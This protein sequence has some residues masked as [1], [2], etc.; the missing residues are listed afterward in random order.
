MEPT[1][2]DTRNTREDWGPPS[3]SQ[4]IAKSR[5]VSGC[6][7]LCEQCSKVPFRYA[8]LCALPDD[9]P[10]FWSLGTFGDLR[11]RNCPFC[12]LVESVCWIGSGSWEQ[13]TK[14]P[15]DSA[16]I[17]IQWLRDKNSFRVNEALLGS[18][19]CF[20]EADDA[21]L[22]RTKG[23][24][25]GWI[26]TAICKRWLSECE[27]RH[28][29]ECSPTPFNKDQ[30]RQGDS[31][32]LI[33][34][35]V[36]VEAMCIMDAPKSCRYLALSYVWGNSKD[37]RLV[38]NTDNKHVLAKPHALR[39]YWD[40]IPKT[41]S[42]AMKLVKDLGERYLWV[43]S[44]CLTQD[45]EK[46]LEV[47][48]TA[49][50]KYY[51]MAILTI[52]AASG[53][54][55]Y[56][57]LPGVHPTPRR[58]TKIVKQVLPA[59]WMTTMQDLDTFLDFSYYRGRGWTMQE[60]L[61]SSRIL[62][63][64]NNQVYF[65]CHSKT[66]NEDAAIGDT[67]GSQGAPFSSMQQIVRFPDL[68]IGLSNIMLY[69]TRRQLTYPTDILRA[70]H[71]MLQ[72]L[73]NVCGEKL[74]EGLPT[75]LEQSLL[76]LTDPLNQSGLR[77]QG[78][79]SYSWTGWKHA[80][81]WKW[82]YQY[83]AGLGWKPG[84]SLKPTWITWYK[85]SP[86]G[87]LHVINQ[88]KSQEP[89]ANKGPKII[90][91]GSGNNFQMFLSTAVTSQKLD[92]LPT[93]AYDILCF[94]TVSIFLKITNPDSHGRRVA[95]GFEETW[96]CD[97]RLDADDIDINTVQRVALV[98]EYEDQGEKGWWG[99][100]LKRTTGSLV[101]RRGILRVPERIMNKTLPPGPIWTCIKL[102]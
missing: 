23:A 25:E 55:A 15:N 75:P 91:E 96:F 56:A 40:I 13:P 53:T 3:A 59:I 19:I 16:E 46:E 38:L 32:P 20:S 47:C 42:S 76:F 100:L 67:L 86:N 73:A 90:R 36:D 49:M 58:S 62:V 79:P 31:I 60:E 98:V 69:Y 30:L 7:K 33:M 57:G 63:F 27:N 9:P 84:G 85:R 52:V 44:L 1:A 70:C 80:S 39:A 102:G 81:T 83:S 54:D 8:Q 74:V 87:K 72:K 2:P 18:F 6:M 4:A 12:Q 82:H 41:I 64:I 37:G 10:P 88:R 94:R 24:L 77:R 65:R 34:R 14:K 89:L 35:L 26:D 48:T 28:R 92:H 45:D 51:S 66:F 5:D 71:G 95:Y 29:P 97:F 61:C 43:D 21:C 93:L 101:E 78:F 50:D 99:I 11:S 17:S 68:T 22:V